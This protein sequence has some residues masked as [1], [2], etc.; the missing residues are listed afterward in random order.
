[1]YSHFNDTFFFSKASGVIDI[2]PN[3]IFME[4]EHDIYCS[5]CNNSVGVMESQSYFGRKLLYT[6][7]RTSF[8]VRYEE[9]VPEKI[10]HFN[11]PE[12]PDPVLYNQLADNISA[13][14]P[15]VD[16]TR[17]DISPYFYK[18]KGEK[19]PEDAEPDFRFEADY[20]EARIPN[21]EKLSEN[22]TSEVDDSM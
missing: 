16:V 17:E 6:V 15:D 8:A 20:F 10:V 12:L 4:L 14:F 1:M 5:N 3:D 18:Y 7:P 19:I 2:Y 21:K 22:F 9:P 11:M 13:S